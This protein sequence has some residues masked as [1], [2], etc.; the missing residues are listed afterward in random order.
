MERLD[1]MIAIKKDLIKNG[2]SAKNLLTRKETK[3][4]GW[5]SYPPTNCSNSTSISRDSTSNQLRIIT[6]QS[7]GSHNL[8]SFQQ[9]QSIDGDC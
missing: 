4:K 8:S 2:Y 9:S 5:E 3:E 7:D 1:D 6:M